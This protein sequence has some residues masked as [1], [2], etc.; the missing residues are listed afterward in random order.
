MIVVDNRTGDGASEIIDAFAQKYKDVKVI[1]RST[2]LFPHNCAKEAYETAEGDLK[3]Y[4]ETRAWGK[5]NGWELENGVM[6]EKN[7][8]GCEY[9][10]GINR[11][12]G[13]ENADALNEVCSQEYLMQED[14][15]KR[16]TEMLIM[17][18]KCGMT[19]MLP[20]TVGHLSEL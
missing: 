7:P 9:R 5:M 2:R 20:K 8:K 1:H 19:K 13:V 6:V 10:F 17:Q 11:I 3:N 12:L 16:T 14:Y 18:E 15:L 4:V